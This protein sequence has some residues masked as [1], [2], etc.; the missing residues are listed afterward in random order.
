MPHTDTWPR[1]T[2]PVKLGAI[3]NKIRCGK[4]Y[5]N[6][7]EELLSMGFN[8]EHQKRGRSVSRDMEVEGQEGEED[9]EGEEG[10][11]GGEEEEDEEIVLAE[12][13]MMIEDR[14]EDEEGEGDEEVGNEMEVDEKEDEEEGEVGLKK[15]MKD[16]VLRNDSMPKILPFS[17]SHVL[18]MEPDQNEIETDSD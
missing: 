15:D 14:E 1:E 17:Y 3:V 2:W 11:E 18:Q 7:R 6:K 13:D 10:D 16:I 12:G 5:V 8:F 4:C 9:N